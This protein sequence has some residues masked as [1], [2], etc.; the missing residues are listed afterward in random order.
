MTFGALPLSLL[1]IS[2]SPS[3]NVS[4]HLKK[5]YTTRATG[6]MLLEGLCVFRGPAPPGALNLQGP[7]TKMGPTP[8]GNRTFIGPRAAKVLEVQG[9][10]DVKGS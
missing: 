5:P 3:P 8:L 1:F 7:C 2:T 6:A 9:Y 4:M 10:L